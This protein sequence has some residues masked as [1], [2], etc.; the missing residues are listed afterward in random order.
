MCD[1]CLCLVGGM[2][3]TV[4]IL[5]ENFGTI[6]STVTL[7]LEVQDS[8]KIENVKAKI[9]DKEEIPVCQQRLFLGGKNLEDS[10]MLSDYNIWDGSSMYLIRSLFNCPLQFEVHV[11]IRY[12]TGRI[13]TLVLNKSDTIEIVKEK[14]KNKDGIPLDRQLLI[15]SGKELKDA[16]TLSSYNINIQST[17]HLVL[18]MPSMKIYVI[19]QTNQTIRLY[20]EAD[21]TIRTVKAKIQDKEGIQHYQQK[22]LFDGEELN[23]SQTLS[24]SKI[25][26]KSILRLILPIWGSMHIHVH[27]INFLPK[28][29]TLQV[30]NSDTIQSVKAKITDQEKFPIN[31]QQL[32]FSRTVLEDSKTLFDYNIQREATL[33]LLL[34]FI[35]HFQTSTGK[36]IVLETLYT[37]SIRKLKIKIE[38]KEGV[39]LERQRFLFAGQELNDDDMTLYDYTN[40]SAVTVYVQYNALIQIFV[41]VNLPT[42]IFY[43][44][45]MCLNLVGKM[46]ACHVKSMIEYQKGIPTYVQTLLFDGVKLENHKSLSE[47]NIRDK[48]TLEL[49]VEMK[50][51]VNLSVTVTDL[52]SHSNQVVQCGNQDTV[53]SIRARLSIDPP[54]KHLYYGAVMLDESRKIQDYLIK[55]ESTL[56]SVPIGLVPL[57]LRHLGSYQEVLVSVNLKTDTIQMVKNK[58]Q[59]GRFGSQLQK[60]SDHL[61]FFENTELSDNKTICECNIVAGSELRVVGPGEV[62]VCIKTRFVEVFIG[63]KGSDTIIKLKDKISRH[64]QISIPPKYQ[65]LIFNQKVL[66]NS[67]LFSSKTLGHYNISVGATIHLVV[68]PGELEVFVTQ[69]SGSTL[70]LI[71]SNDDTVGDVKVMIERKESVPVQHQVLPFDCD[72]KTLGNLNISPGSDLKLKIGEI[73]NYVCLFCVYL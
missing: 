66:S 21:D 45:R 51:V 49:V 20:V 48:C 52:F 6:T 63:V 70:T 31:H 29:I 46:H 26:D 53:G 47:Y 32:V 12:L 22:L 13:I 38:M 24:G 17:I 64:P 39:P 30:E 73:Y 9:Q 34:K 56:Y 11:T 5:K 58:L 55:N 61:L 42:T 23:N 57:V 71:C 18:Q 27:F 60:T 14:I 54:E 19:T 16:C 68:F 37:D 59:D 3:I 50:H 15:Y 72:E 69:P 1:L 8:E 2:L 43:Q 40:G 36:T 35:I 41:E 25:C 28:T 10:R 4:K 62:P 44:G 33:Y 7:R 65:R 67:G